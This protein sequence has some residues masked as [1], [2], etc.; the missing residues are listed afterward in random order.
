MKTMKRIGMLSLMLSLVAHA[1]IGETKEQC[2]ARYQ[3]PIRVNRFDNMFAKKGLNTDCTFDDDGRCVRVSYQI[4][5]NGAIP[6]QKGVKIPKFTDAQ[7]M[8]LLALNSGGSEWEKKSN[9]QFGSGADGKYLTKDGSRQALV[10]SYGVK[11]ESV[12]YVEAI[13]KL[14]EPAALDAVIE[15]VAK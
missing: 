15:E 11:I 5:F 4:I 14:V 2:K 12:A 9:D 8:K 13:C 7:V 6:A 10:N 1:K 3:D